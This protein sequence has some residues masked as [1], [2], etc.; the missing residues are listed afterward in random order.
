MNRKMKLEEA[1]GR[2][3]EIVSALHPG[4][5]ITLTSRN[6]PVATIIPGKRP[7]HRR[8]HPGKTPPMGKPDA[9]DASF[10]DFRNYV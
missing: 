6:Q 9:L 1:S 8:V 3:V 10:E 7:Q 5:E 4:D 2:L